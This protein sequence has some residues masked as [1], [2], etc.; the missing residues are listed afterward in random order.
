MA[1]TR[2]L[3]H[4]QRVLDIHTEI[5]HRVLDLGVAQQY[6]YGAQVA[7]GLLPKRSEFAVRR[8]IS[9]TGWGDDSDRL[10]GLEDGFGASGQGL[11]RAVPAAD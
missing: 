11:E 3:S 2:S 5:L 1:S 6:L 10:A 8:S 4:M 7:C 9:T